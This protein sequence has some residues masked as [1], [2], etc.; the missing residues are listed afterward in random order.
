[1]YI[2]KERIAVRVSQSGHDPLD[3][4]FALASSS[5][6]GVGPRTILELLNSSRRV[7]PFIVA[8]DGNV[9][10]LTRLNLDW[11]MAGDR[12][13]VGLVLPFD[14]EI[15]REEP[16][17]LHFMNGTTIDGLL[18]I[19]PTSEGDRASDF[20]NSDSDFYPVRTHL[21]M[22]L[23]NKCRVRDTQLSTVSPHWAH[24]RSEEKSSAG[25]DP[26]MR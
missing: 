5:A 15:V 9:I 6:D 22:L 8:G 16:V 11:V 13:P 24:H 2:V 3:G 25:V 19:S 21:G 4:F 7:V 14:V 17:A 20:L 12:V 1:M 10:L 18:Q 26:R 23:V